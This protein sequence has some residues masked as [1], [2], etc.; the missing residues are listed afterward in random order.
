VIGRT[1]SHYQI[2]REIGSGGM[3]VV[4]LAWDEHLSC[5]V[6]LKVL[7]AGLLND[8]TARRRFRREALT[9]AARRHPNIVT[10]HDFDTCDGVDFLVME[11]VEGPSLAEELEGGS[12]PEERIVDL[13]IQLAQGLAA[14]HEAGIIHRDLKPTNLKITRDGVLKILDFGLAKWQPHGHE[15]SPYDE[16][17]KPGHAAGTLPYMAPELLQGSQPSE[18]C[19]VYSAGVVLYQMASGRLP[20]AS[21]SPSVLVEEIVT[22]VPPPPTRWNPRLAP[23]LET[24]ILRAMAK[25]PAARP[26]AAALAGDLKAAGRAGPRLG[27]RP[28]RARR[29]WAISAA[30]LVSASLLLAVPGVRG[31]VAGWLG[32][33]E[34]ATVASLAVLPLE[35]LSKDPEQEYFADGMTEELITVLAGI[36]RLH[37]ISRT[38]VMEFKGTHRPTREIAK[39]LGVRQIL[40]GSVLRSGSRVRINAQ[41]IDAVHDRHLWAESYEGELSDALA[42]QSEVARAISREVKVTLSPREEK[43]FEKPSRVDPEAYEAYLRGLELWNSRR[44]EQI[45]AAIALFEKSCRLDSTFAK[46]HAGLADAYSL[47]GNLGVLPQ[48]SAAAKAG[49]EAMRAL[50]LDP[51]LGEAHASL[52]SID[53]EFRWDW[54]GA[55]REFLRAIELNPGYATAHQWYADYLSRVGRAPEALAESRRALSLDPLSPAVNGLLGTVYYYA[56]RPDDAIRQYRTT[57]ALQPGQVLTRFYL[58][59]AYLEKHAYPQAIAE[60]ERCVQD[61]NGLPLTRAGLACAHALAGDRAEAERILA[62]LTHGPSAERVSPSYLALVYV[63]LGD[64]DKALRAME[65]AADA[66]DSYLGHIKVLPLLDPVRGDPRFQALL[67]RVGLAP[68]SA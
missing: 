42:L 10:V 56:R 51:E 3:G 64:R 34:D 35:N 33:G 54:A 20:H 68:A 27:H 39:R 28:H 13:G 46:P 57:L 49:A 14:A 8:E 47:L 12:L 48:S 22:R 58:G 23:Q 11:H 36:E 37:V 43:R 1:I 25:D 18:K 40:E 21:P 65:R 59:L 7:P 30:A 55:E 4:Y 44:P 66:R 17:T 45:Q 50:Q 41:L 5:E 38:S 6:V 63:G 9:L 61:A 53:M 62:D 29:W 15:T 52:A 2:L 32:F 67:R 16:I 60:F 31:R 26:G 24:V 19:D